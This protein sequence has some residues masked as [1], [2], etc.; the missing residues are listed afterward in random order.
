MEGT[1]PYFRPSMMSLWSPLESRTC[2]R[3]STKSGRKVLKE[4]V[5][6]VVIAGELQY[7]KFLLLELPIP[8]NLDAIAIDSMD[9]N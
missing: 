8:C 1:R 3:T 7:N 2:C 6:W 4:S 5:N 9:G